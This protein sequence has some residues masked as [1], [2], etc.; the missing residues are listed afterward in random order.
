MAWSL[1]ERAEF[2]ARKRHEFCRLLGGGCAVKG[3][4]RLTLTERRAER[5]LDIEQQRPAAAAAAAAA[6][7]PTPVPAAA[8]A[9]EPAAKRRRKKRTGKQK[10]LSLA[11]LQDFQE[12]KRQ[13]LYA[14]CHLR[15]YLQRE[16]RRIRWER[17]QAVWTEHMR[18]KLAQRQLSANDSQPAAKRSRSPTGEEQVVTARTPIAIRQPTGGEQE[19][20]APVA[21]ITFKETVARHGRGELISDAE[22]KAAIT[23]FW[24]ENPAIVTCTSPWG[25]AV[26]RRLTRPRPAA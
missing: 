9:A 2:A 13:K 15:I 23:N 19:V 5:L 17:M 11:R 12:K 1:A 8:A 4:H 14:A 10:E 18:E 16:L 6:A 21:Q 26:S 20:S 25:G 22:K 3:L 7:V 24:L